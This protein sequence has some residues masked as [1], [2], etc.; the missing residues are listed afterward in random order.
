[1]IR[2]K[3]SRVRSAVRHRT[4]GW[5]TWC[6]TMG[7]LLLVWFALWGAVSPWLALAGIAA[8][9][10]L[11]L[12]FPLPVVEFSFGLHPWRTV[13]LIGRFFYD[14]LVA[15]AQVAWLA[16]RPRPPAGAITT[17]QLRSTSDLVQTLVSL[18][19][20][21]VPGSLIIEADPENRTL[22]IHVLDVKPGGLSA[23]HRQVLDQEERILQALG[24]KDEIDAVM[25]GE[26][27]GELAMHSGAV[28]LGSTVL[29]GDGPRKD[30]GTE[31]RA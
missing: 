12:L 24:S 13:V 19:V 25:I 6:I 26:D 3:G 4:G 22:V 14:V 11:L 20:S 18:A 5:R 30:D 15:S 16:V 23:F 17:V 7:W 21:L 28:T 2:G 31:E 1:M 29:L 8:S 10:A 27:D 9:A